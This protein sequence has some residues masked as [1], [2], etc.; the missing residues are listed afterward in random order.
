M[1]ATTLQRIKESI[2]SIPDYPIPGIM[3]RDIT[4][5]IEN[6]AAF[7]DTI[8]LLVARYKDQNIDKVVGTEARGFIFGAPLAAAIGAG[9]VPVRKP[10]KL[11]R[12]T[13]H[14]DYELEYGTDT[15]HIHSDAIKQGERVLLV[16][17]LLATGGTA[18]ASVKL[19]QRSGGTVIESAFVI[20]LPALKGAE[21][22]TALNVPHF[23]LIEFEGE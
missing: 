22:L 6:G 18:Q 12:T 21:K 13:V 8:N 23:S 11:P 9:F 4:S 1:T 3:F 14:E 15:L 17:D 10:G 19:I 20:E 7:S 5:L 2:K 16:D